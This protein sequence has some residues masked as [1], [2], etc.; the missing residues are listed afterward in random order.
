[1]KNYV[2][3]LADGEKCVSLK[4]D[5]AKGYQR[6]AMAL[7]GLRKYEDAMDC[8]DKASEID[9]NNAQFKAGMRGVQ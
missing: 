8:Y 4:A 7:H 3:A 9:P 2:D 5:W 1:M 6:K